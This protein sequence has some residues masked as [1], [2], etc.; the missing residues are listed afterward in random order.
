[1]DRTPSFDRTVSPRSAR[2]RFIFTKIADSADDS[3]NYIV[4]SQVTKIVRIQDIDIFM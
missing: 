1:M 4:L 2:R 3:V